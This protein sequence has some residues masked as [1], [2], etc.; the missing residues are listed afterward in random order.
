MLPALSSI[1]TTLTGEVFTMNVSEDC[2]RH[3]RLGNCPSNSVS[4]L[5]SLSK[6]VTFHLVSPGLHTKCTLLEPSIRQANMASMQE[7]SSHSHRRAPTKT[8]TNR[9][10]VLRSRLYT[11]PDY[12]TNKTL[13]Q[14]QT[15]S[16]D[17]SSNSELTTV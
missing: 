5:S 9:E 13:S 3:P 17:F 7:R 2:G 14:S 6:A 11:T 10:P 8:S 4:R 16:H 15:Q 12:S 1:T